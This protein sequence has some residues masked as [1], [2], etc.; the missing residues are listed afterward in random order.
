M[1]ALTQDRDTQRRDGDIFNLP[2]GAGATIFAGAIVMLNAAGYA[3]AGAAATGQVCAGR[4]EEPAAN[5]AGA[6]GAVTVNVRSGVFKYAAADITIAHV[7]DTCF[8]VDD[9]TV[10]I[11]DGVA[12]RS[13]AGVVVGVEADGVW[14]RMGL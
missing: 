8:I 2:V 13:A 7:G 12:T 4:A 5:S 1:V 10:S 6:D 11:S 14:V 3:V 9:Q